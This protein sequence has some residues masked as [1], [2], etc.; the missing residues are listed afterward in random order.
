M[1]NYETIT[2]KLVEWATRNEDIRALV[3]IGS[4][5]RTNAPTNCWSDADEWSDLD[6]IV[7]AQDISVYVQT[8]DWIHAFGKPLLTFTETAFDGSVERRVLYEGFLDVDFALSDP[9]GFRRELALD[10][11]RAIF[12]RGYRV[13]LDKD[14][15]QAL[16]QEQ[17]GAPQDHALSRDEIA[18]EIQDYW[19][20]CVWLAKKVQRGEL[21][22]AVR[23]LN[24][25][26]QAK[27]LRMIEISYRL[28]RE[29]GVDTWHNG[30]FLE[31]W[32][33]PAIIERL[34]GCFADY[35]LPVLKRA[36]GRHMDLYHDL[37][38]DVAAKLGIPY[39]DEARQ[40]V[41]EWINK[42]IENT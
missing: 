36:L 1:N 17:C 12:R 34:K 7:I 39:P 3:L 18:N 10:A 5:A 4:R 20:H 16:I 24:G 32:A 13:L 27:L 11:V 21:W 25:Y 33:D 41:I 38:L 30:R 42:T 23:C 14:G 40:Q 26:M 19:Y 15:W 9:D 22:T 8:A 35:D 37:A 28:T 2:N 6:V 29:D 31:K